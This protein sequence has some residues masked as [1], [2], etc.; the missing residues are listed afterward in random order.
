MIQ[1]IRQKIINVLGR[2]HLHVEEW[3][4][5]IF[6][7]LTPEQLSNDTIWKAS[8][9]VLSFVSD[10]ILSMVRFALL[11]LTPSSLLLLCSRLDASFSLLTR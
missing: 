1:G 5:E 8:D 2:D 4:K 7:R 6:N 9:A 11:L 10:K 3:D